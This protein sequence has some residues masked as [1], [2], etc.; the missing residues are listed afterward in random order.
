MLYSSNTMRWNVG[1][2]AHV[3]GNEYVILNLRIKKLQQN[4]IKIWRSNYAEMM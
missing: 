2:A 3:F 4:D 1:V